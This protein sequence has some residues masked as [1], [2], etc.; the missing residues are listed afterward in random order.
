MPT[1]HQSWLRRQT[2]PKRPDTVPPPPPFIIFFSLPSSFSIFCYLTYSCPLYSHSIP[3]LFLCSSTHLLHLI[4]LY[5]LYLN[6]LFSSSYLTSSLS[7]LLIFPQTTPL[8]PS[9]H[10]PFLLLLSYLKFFLHLLL[11]CFLGPDRFYDN[12]ADMI[13][14]RPHPFMKYCWTY[15]TPLMC[16]VSSTYTFTFWPHFIFD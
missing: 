10:L 15:I 12:I 14:Y 9:P 7:V 5:P 16:F 8:S 3:P 6:I 13:G 4:H 11:S 1:I 2:S